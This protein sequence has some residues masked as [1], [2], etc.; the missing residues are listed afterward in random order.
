M[1]SITELFTDYVQTNAHLSERCNAFMTVRMTHGDLLQ[2]GN[3]KTK[4]LNI[5]K[6]SLAVA[7][8]G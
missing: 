7:R 6:P 5:K 1:K 3:E 2:T 4:T 8:D